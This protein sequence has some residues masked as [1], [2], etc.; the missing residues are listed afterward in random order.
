MPDND[1][2]KTSDAC[3]VVVLANE[4]MNLNTS[5][6]KKIKSVLAPVVRLSPRI[7]PRLK[8]VN[9]IRE[10]HK[11]NTGIWTST[12]EDPQFRCEFPL[13]DLHTGWYMITLDIECSNV[14]DTAKFYVNQGKG[15][16]EDEAIKIPYQSRKISK[17]I[18][19]FNRKAL[20]IRFDP[21]SSAGQF[22]VREFSV[23]PVTFKFAE[24]RMIGKLMRW[25][26]SNHQH[27]VN[28]TR[29]MLKQQAQQAGQKYQ[30]VLERKYSALFANPMR[31][32]NYSKWIENVEILEIPTDSDIR[33]IERGT[34]RPLISIIMPTYNSDVALLNA[35]IQ[36]VTS[37]S[38]TNWQ[39]C[40]SDDGSDSD[41]VKEAIESWSKKNEKIT[42]VFGQQG[43][44]I[45]NNTNSALQL[46]RGD[47]C[48]FLDHD[49][50]L[51]EHAL[52]EVAKA[53]VEKPSLKLVY[54]DEDKID[55]TGARVDPHF[56]PDWNPDL[57]LSQNYICHLV[58][59]R[60]DVI[61][62]VGGCRTG[63]EG[64]QDHDLLLRVMEVVTGDE[65]QHIAKILYH[66]RMAEG[67]TASVA[68]AKSYTTDS[69]VA[70]INDHLSRVGSDAVVEAAK[71]PNTYRV[72]WSLPSTAPKVSI[73][74]PTRDRLD[75]LSQCIGSVLQRTDYPDYEIIVIDNESTEPTTLDYLEQ[76][77]TQENVRIL[78]YAG[79]FNYSA[80]NNYAVS[81]A[82]GSIITMMNNDIEVIE[83]EWL[84]EMVGHALRSE[85]GC[86]GAKLL[87]KNNMVQHAGVILGIGGVAGHSHKY[88]DAESAGYFSRLHLTQNMSAVTAACLTVEKSIYLQVGGLNESDLKVAFNDVDFCLRVSSLGLRNVW[89]PY[90]LLYHH[91]S[92][93]RG[94]ENTHEKQVRFKNE[95]MYMQKQWG[96]LLESDPAYNSNLTLVRE[97]FSLAA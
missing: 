42:A 93:S 17:R 37:Q 78:K 4:S 15:H 65:V 67:S 54:S 38:Y 70:A 16:L 9:D 59:L 89:T 69:G 64:A 83:K 43:A 19:K 46:A 13:L 23:S 56:K 47:Y 81:Q 76:L 91:E 94:H 27:T 66:W 6:I 26:P 51:V 52:Y 28:A 24:N 20:D 8:P 48:I 49:D 40:I 92:V 68:S 73:I 63:F 97:D 7:R 30:T 3:P 10:R 18:V 32:H 85:V 95:A 41:E 11:G 77:K 44:G 45:A 71:Y 2:L 22:S 31:S 5:K 35:A 62:Q 50:L 1:C 29:Q 25:S 60:R 79:E 58:A 88:F 21:L 72:R 84:R 14:F 75:I 80:I 87:Y 53:I 90:A 61:Q 12:G 36:S 33:R 39:L 82:N 34:V 74:I 86:V 96:E 55:S 57:L